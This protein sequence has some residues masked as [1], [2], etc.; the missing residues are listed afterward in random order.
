MRKCVDFYAV[1]EYVYVS[2]CEC[3]F[4][5]R[6]RMRMCAYVYVG[7]CECVFV[8]RERMRMYAY[9][10]EL[11]TYGASFKCS[12]RIDT[13]THTHTHTAKRCENTLAEYKHTQTHTSGCAGP[14]RPG[15]QARVGPDPLLQQDTFPSC[16]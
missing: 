8:F 6:E 15:A 2:V 16:I 7:V 1:C 10:Y 13:H 14:Y 3:V 12:P 11:K 9:V 4:I 5:L